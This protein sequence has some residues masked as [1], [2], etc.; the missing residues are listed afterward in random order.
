MLIK[1]EIP[2]G[3][4]KIAKIESLV[5]SRDGE[6]RSAKVR[7]SSGRVIGRPLNLLYPIEFSDNGNESD[8]QNKLSETDMKQTTKTEHRRRNDAPYKTVYTVTIYFEVSTVHAC[9]V[10]GVL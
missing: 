9:K 1:D 5:C 2:R 4:W 10:R 7:L 8:F 6:I 3:C